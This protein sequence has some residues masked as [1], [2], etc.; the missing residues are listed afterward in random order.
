MKKK[1]YKAV[2]LEQVHP[3]LFEIFQE[4]NI[5]VKDLSN[6]ENAELLRELEDADILIVRSKK[7][8]K[9]IIDN[10]KQLKIIGRAG[11]GLENIDIKYAESKGI[12]CI[13]SPEGNRDAVG[14]HA[15]GMLLMLLNKLKKA[16]NE[17]RQGIWDRKS[18]WGIEL[19]YLQVGI[20]GYGNMGSAF[21]KKLSGFECPILVYDKY[22]KDIQDTFV[23]VV[24]INDIFENADVVSLHLPLNEETFYYA[25]EKFFER[26]KKS[27]YFINTSRGKILKSSALVKGLKSGK[28]KGA[29]L[30]VLE[31]E[32]INF[33]EMNGT[34]AEEFE[35]LR[36]CENVILTPHIAGWTYQ[37]YEKICKIL[38]EKILKEL[39]Q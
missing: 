32:G 15:I 3:S 35:Y 1:L 34:Q 13:N 5:E 26:F 4:K 20:I 9:T 6:A 33:E 17:V 21:A 23:N 24:D 7:I 14:E 10:T 39:G 8:D 28:I 31:Y 30:D 37:S 18:N 16:D 12:K 11:S 2:V 36:N 25:D 19:K 29:C 38:A 27:I 22:K